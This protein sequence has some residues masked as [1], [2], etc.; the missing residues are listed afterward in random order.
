MNELATIRRA[1]R[2]VVA[3]ERRILDALTRVDE[4][5]SGLGFVRR[6]PHRWWP[7]YTSFPSRDW[8]AKSWAW[9]HV[10]CY[11]AR[12]QWTNGD[13]NA[14]GTRYLLVDHIADTAFEAKRL[15]DKSEPEPLQGLPAAE[16]SRTILRWLVLELAAPVPPA[17]WKLQWNDFFARN[18]G[19]TAS[20]LLPAT[21]TA[22]PARREANGVTLIAWC[23][24]LATVDGPDAFGARCIEPLVGVLARPTP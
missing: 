1:Y 20:S 7:L 22:T 14:A 5:V 4:A 3:Y 9:D 12:F 17:L 24:D 18:F 23:T 13:D 21:E 11:A 10:P 15:A 16:D 6:T 19:V 8:P 2:Y